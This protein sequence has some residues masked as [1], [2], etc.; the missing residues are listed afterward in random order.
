[1]FNVSKK[2]CTDVMLLLSSYLTA[3]FSVS[4]YVTVVSGSEVSLEGYG[5]FGVVFV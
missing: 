2:F 4:M 1:M 3:C 5:F